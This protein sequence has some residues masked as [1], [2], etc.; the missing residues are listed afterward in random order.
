MKTYKQIDLITGCV[1][2]ITSILL[3]VFSKMDFYFLGYFVVGGW[4]LISAIAHRLLRKHYIY[5]GYRKIYEVLLVIL[6]TTGVISY[7][8]LE[9]SQGELFILFL[10]ALLYFG[11]LIAI[12]YQIV[13]FIE[14]R[15]LT[16]RA[17][18]HLKN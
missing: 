13:C 9:T 16:K 17:F 15:R 1:L 5:T 2:I 11:P 18:I 14:Y 7:F 3:M 10:Y 4:Q 6:L 12:Y 8:I